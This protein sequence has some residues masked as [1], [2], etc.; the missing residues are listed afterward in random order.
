MAQPTLAHRTPVACSACYAQYPDRKHI[1][2]R[3]MM[4]GLQPPGAGPR[5]PHVDWVTICENCLR[6]GLALLPEE[7]GPREK[8]EQRV[9]DLEEQLRETQ[10]YADR[11]ED[12]LSAR[13]AVRDRQR[14]AA[15][16]NRYEGKQ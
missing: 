1:D 14:T 8:L 16:K 2:Y 7:A 6:S 13:P 4:N 12:A 15:R 10:A 9:A 5:D 11:V 3:S